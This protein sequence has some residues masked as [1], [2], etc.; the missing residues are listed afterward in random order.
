M[1]LFGGQAAQPGAIIVRQRG[2]EFHPG[3]GVGMGRDH[4]LFCLAPG[5]VTFER[6]QRR[7]RT[8]ISVRPP[9]AA[10]AAAAPAPAAA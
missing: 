5:R 7:K 8:Y 6:D 9:P 4:T 3:F 10:A 1:K 2:T